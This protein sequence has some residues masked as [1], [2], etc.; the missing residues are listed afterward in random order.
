MT[1]HLPL[2]HDRLYRIRSYEPRPDGLAPITAICNQLQDI[3]SGHADALG[4]GYHDL[5][6][7]GHFWLLA[8]LHVMMDRLPAYG[9]A[10]RVQTWPS[11]NERLVANRDFLILDP[12]AAQET[13]MGRATSSWVTMNASTHRP[14]SPSE[15]LSTRFIPD[16]ER[17]LTFPAKS[18]TRLKDGEHETGLTARRADLD[19]NGH[20]NNVRYAELCLEAV[21]QAWEAA[22]RCLGLDIQFRSESF[23]GDAYVSACAEAGPDSG[24][25]TLLHRLTRINDDREIVRMRSWW[26]TG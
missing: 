18:I 12:A 11:G 15:V 10:V 17:A 24:M 6:T 3:A 20:V 19:I 16:R 4:F 8:R 9:G 13:V 5:E 21:P 25:R 23:A 1:A 7:G 14:E 2:T 22:H 26:Q